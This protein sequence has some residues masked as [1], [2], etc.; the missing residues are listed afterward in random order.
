MESFIQGGLVA[1]F[2]TILVLF[3]KSK[4]N[5]K[6]FPPGPGA[7][8]LSGN[9]H[10]IL[11]KEPWLV[12][13]KW[14]KTYG[15]LV[16]FHIF[17]KRVVIINSATAAVEL[18]DGRS[19]IYSD[20]PFS[21]MAGEL[22]RRKH[23]MFHLSSKNPRFKV[24]RWLLHSGLNPRTAL[25]YRPIQ[26]QEN[27]V[28]LNGLLNNPAGFVQH[29]R[30]NAGAVIL[31]VAYG[32][33]VDSDNDKFVR[34][35]E[36]GFRASATSGVSV[37]GKYLVESFP[38]LRFLPS[39]FPGASF[40]TTAKRL[41]QRMAAME[42]A[43]FEW[44]QKNIATGNYVDSF[45]SKHLTSGTV[46][47]QD[48]EN[49]RWCSAALYAGGADTV[50]SA[51]TAFI[52]LMTLHPDI[53]RQGQAELDRAIGDRLPTFE[54]QEL[55]P[56]VSAIIKETLR[57]A[58]VAPLGLPHRVTQDDIYDGYFI[59]KGTQLVANIWAITHDSDLYPDPLVFNPSRHLGDNPQP[60][61]FRHIFGYGRRACPGAHFAE[62]SLFLNTASIL[63][64]FNIGKAVDEDGKEIEPSVGWTTGPTSHPLPF[65]CH[66]SPRSNDAATLIKSAII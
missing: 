15:P 43:P 41:G 38:I 27:R 51:L 61:P 28:L 24:Y 66:I 32:Y 12:F 20:R 8:F 2:I 31:K 52:L 16:H 45:I 46:T 64:G 62:L 40:K 1:V 63:A 23:S 35:I 36:E 3:I 21:W 18:L 14:S 55:L 26:L 60:D 13:K 54:D 59:P 17:N 30:R 53:Q 37:P 7:K 11:S 49:L 34:G 22:A 9:F 42:R 65:K 5:R 10:Q 56:Y 6:P 44:A 29:I 4:Y 47:E 19:T 57:W 39:W 25:T 58:P 50:A 48:Q 33:Q